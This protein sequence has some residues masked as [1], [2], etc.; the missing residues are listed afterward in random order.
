M[1]LL[2]R[3]AWLAAL[4]VPA[5][6][7]A[8]VVESLVFSTPVEGRSAA[9]GGTLIADLRPDLHGAAMQPAFLDP[10]D[11]GRIAAD[12]TDYFAGMRLASVVAPLRVKT[13][14]GGAVRTWAVGARMHDYGA[15]AGTDATG[16]ETG[17]F[18][19]GDYA[20]SSTWSWRPDSVWSVGV[21]AWGGMRHLERAAVGWAGLDL[22]VH[23][24]W[25]DRGWAVGAALT[26]WGGQFGASGTWPTGRHPAN[27]Q[28]GVSRGFAHAPF[29]LYARAGHLL[30]W[31]LAPPGIYDDRIDPLTGDTLA[32]R[33]WA[34]GDRL[35]R[36]VGLGTELRLSDALRFQIGYD[37]RRRKELASGGRAGTAGL[38][39]GISFRVKTFGLQVSRATYHFAGS[40]THLGVTWNPS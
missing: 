14:A 36:H 18:R 33:T 27:L 22:G 6:G 38:A 26:G 31:D 20:V 30:T 25:P 12:F 8:Q 40:S 11:K 21:S 13:G 39:L 29:T 24:R 19:G 37:Y 23:G 2:L 16:A 15:F 17:S 4:L 28:L 5:A 7:T 3:H 1:T 9:L 10:Q 32:N 34:F 35:M